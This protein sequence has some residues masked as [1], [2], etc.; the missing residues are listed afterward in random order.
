MQVRI[1]YASRAVGPQT[2][3]VTSAILATAQAFNRQ[4]GISGVL[5][6]GQGLYLQVLEGE[7]SAVHALYARIVADRRH[8]DVEML[9]L[10]EITERCYPEWSMALVDL[11][12]EDAMVQMKHPEFDPY[13]APGVL[14]MALVEEWVAAGRRIELPAT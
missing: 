6:Q 14:V 11:S 5:C 3:T 2:T 12:E 13:S 7:R 4:H 1:L 10:E 9:Q 8:K